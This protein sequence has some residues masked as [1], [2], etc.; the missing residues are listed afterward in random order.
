MSSLPAEEMLDHQC[1]VGI[2]KALRAQ[3]MLWA[4][5]ASPPI[6]LVVLCHAL[7]GGPSRRVIEP[8]VLEMFRTIFMIIGGIELVFSFVLRRYLF[9][10]LFK[11][12]LR[13]YYFWALSKGYSTPTQKQGTSRPEP[14]YLVKSRLKTIIPT[15]LASAAGFL[16]FVQYAQGDS[17]GVFYVFVVFSLLGC[18][19]HRP[20]KQEMLEFRNEFLQ[21]QQP[22]LSDEEGSI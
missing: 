22:A 8:S 21:D 2:A 5:V 16:G 10:P 19:Y 17:L 3:W 13:R 20:K 9:S 11:G 7:G 14:L 15:G 6:V 4:F 18:L 1:E 12:V